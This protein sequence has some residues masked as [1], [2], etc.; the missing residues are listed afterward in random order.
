MHRKA[1]EEAADSAN[2]D[3]DNA[4][5]RRVG[6]ADAVQYFRACPLAA[7]VFDLSVGLPRLGSRTGCATSQAQRSDLG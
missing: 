4:A 3:D 1:E 6:L 7:A 2:G 5:R